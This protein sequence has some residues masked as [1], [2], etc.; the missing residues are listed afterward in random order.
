MKKVEKRVFLGALAALALCAVMN[1]WHYSLEGARGFYV[2]WKTDILRMLLAM[3]LV[4]MTLA[5]LALPL[6]RLKSALPGKVMRG[7]SLAAS[8]AV[9][10]ISIAILAFLIAGPRQG[11]IDPPKLT[12]IDP[13]KGIAYSSPSSSSGAVAVMQAGGTTP[14]KKETAQSHE[15]SA[16][17]LRLSFSSDPHWGAD[18]SDASAR[19]EILASVAE[20]RPDAFFML[21]D[22]T[23]RGSS[24]GH[25][26]SAL[27]DL[28]AI[29]PLV[30][31]RVLLG[32]HDALFGGQYLYKK[33]FF[34]QGY[35]SDSSSPYYYSLKSPDALVV[36]L[37][38]PWGTEDF[39]SRQRGW[40]EKT[41]AGA[42]RS[43]PVI[44]LS[45]SYFY[46]S[47]YDDPVMGKPWYDHR[48]NI[49]AITPLLEKYKVDLVISGHN[50][51][52]EFLKRNGVAYAIIGA[53]GGIPDP[54]P[55]YVSPASVWIAPPATYGRVDVEVG[56][57]GLSVK[58]KNAAG[59]TIHE[60]YLE[61]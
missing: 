40:L 51:Y 45:H 17:R 44:V 21:G 50:H 49:P 27:A 1:G 13:S 32:N 37:H 20:Y 5:I 8:S 16:P 14:A 52:Q 2:W 53:M 12:L 9:S 34:P 26:E 58:F 30:P 61:K 38:L 36:V 11:D 54:A 41:L 24:A 25:W 23:E 42:D 57:G 43:K 35:A 28:E 7:L 19:T 56:A 31:L 39:R 55:S 15:S 4:P 6:A 60:E 33:L 47:G 46:A 29:I 18:T 59:V 22:T 3:G 10:L 48:E